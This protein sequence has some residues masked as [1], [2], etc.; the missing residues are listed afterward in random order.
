MSWFWAPRS[1]RAT[2]PTR[3]NEPSGLARNTILP[4]CSGVVRRPCVCRFNWNC[5]SLLIGRAEQARLADPGCARQHVEHI[6]DRVIGNKQR[7]QFAIFAVE[8]K[9][10]Q[11]RRR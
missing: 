6:D 3:T 5:W 2:S 8:H 4:N 10:L 9:E 7:V 1:T 11:H